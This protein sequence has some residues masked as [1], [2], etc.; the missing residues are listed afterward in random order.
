MKP[1]LDRI[2][3]DLA[4]MEKAMGTAPSF[5]REWAQWLRRDNWL[6]LW[7]FLPGIILV[8]AALVPWDNSH[9]IL[10]L[11]PIQWVGV[12]VAAVL[13][14]ML[15]FWNRTVQRAGRPDGLVREYQKINKLAGWFLLPFL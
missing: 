12:L 15:F 9:R 1:E 11:M 2:K 14:G 10:G 3:S 6:G 5:G 4:T 13:L 8:V 7:W